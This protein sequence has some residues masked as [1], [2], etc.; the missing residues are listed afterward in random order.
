MVTIL[1]LLSD[2]Q[3]A[4]HDILIYDL[5][6]PYFIEYWHFLFIIQYFRFDYAV[7]AVFQSANSIKIVDSV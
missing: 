5:I 4:K 7:R 3:Y 1:L 2:I 6:L